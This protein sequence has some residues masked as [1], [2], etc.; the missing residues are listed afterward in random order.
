MP[1]A[2]VPEGSFPAVVGVGP[3]VRAGVSG[4]AGPLGDEG[5]GVAE[6]GRGVLAEDSVASGG[7]V[8]GGSVSAGPDVCAGAVVL[9][10]SAGAVVPGVWTVV[11]PVAG[12]GATSGGRT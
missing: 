11:P 6:V 1:G 3:A 4:A 8:S 12:A 2:C 9:V 7:E 5:P 10:G